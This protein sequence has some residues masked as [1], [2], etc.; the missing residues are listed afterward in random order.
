MGHLTL[1][2]QEGGSLDFWD[3]ERGDSKPRRRRESLKNFSLISATFRGIW[4][5]RV[6]AIFL[7]GPMS[8]PL[9]LPLLR[10]APL[11]PRGGCPPTPPPCQGP[12]QG[13]K[14]RS[15]SGFTFPSFIRSAIHV[16][17]HS[18]GKCFLFLLSARPYT[19]C[20]GCKYEE[21]VVK[22]FQ[23]NLCSVHELPA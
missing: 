12:T 14:S 2:A 18:L 15:S 21:D 3:T 11:A 4:H 20:L 8:P 1:A 16:F 10:P 9:L 17:T 22:T 5:W 6:S 23:R 13:C 7:S 19:R